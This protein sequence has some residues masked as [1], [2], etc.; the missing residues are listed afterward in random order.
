MILTS[1]IYF[2]GQWL[3]DFNVTET[4]DFTTANGE[5]KQVEAMK[6]RKKYHAGRFD[7]KIKARWAAVPYNSTETMVI[8]LPH[9]GENI[10]DIIGQLDGSEM[11]EIIDDVSGYPSNS[12][13]NV[14]LPKFDIKSKIDLK[15]PLQK[16]GI[17]KIFTPESE[18]YLYEGGPASRVA[19]A[20]Q[21]SALKVDEK[22][23]IGA[24]ATA[25]SVVPLTIERDH[26][27]SDFLINRPFIVCII[28]RKYGVPYFIGKISDPTLS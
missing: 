27:D 26:F 17:E 3:F 21:V 5:V 18:L 19:S 4:I 12:W 20:V 28:D 16:M 7:R 1:A 23:S 9:E 13:L 11:T 14:T 6:I 24:S 8:V 10:D 2:K 25:F 15:G 22:G